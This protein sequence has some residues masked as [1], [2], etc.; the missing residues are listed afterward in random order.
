MNF[1]SVFWK[2]NSSQCIFLNQAINLGITRAVLI[3]TLSSLFSM[4]SSKVWTQSMLTPPDS[5]EPSDKRTESRT[6]RHCRGSAESTF[7]VCLWTF[8]TE[9]LKIKSKQPLQTSSH[10]L[11][12]HS[13]PCSS[14]FLSSPSQGTSRQ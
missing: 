4:K 3:L 6:S 5:S 11:D 1:F 10:W 13:H 8:S 2:L 9:E 14:S 7:T 12:S